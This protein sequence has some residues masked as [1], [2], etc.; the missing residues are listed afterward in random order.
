MPVTVVPTPDSSTSRARES[1]ARV[2]VVVD[3]DTIRLETGEAV[4]LLGVDTPEKG[5]PYFEEA[6]R[7]TKDLLVGQPVRLIL[8]AQRES[9]PYD[10]LL[11]FVEAGDRDPGLDLLQQ[12]LAR[13]LFI[14]PCGLDRAPLYRQAE[15]EAF[16][17]GRGIWS[18]QSRRRVNHE[19]AHRYVGSLMSVT[20]RVRKVH[21][22]PKAIHL[23]FGEDYRTD[24]TAVIYRK[25]L[26][27][28]LS[29][30]LEPVTTYAGRWVEVTGHLR[31]YQGPE[32]I[33]DAAD[34]LVVPAPQ[35]DAIPQT[36]NEPPLARP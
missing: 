16:R 14:P 22:G 32:I 27:G 15:R 29:K 33:V 23:D 24:F 2:E 10:R 11:A 7:L 9:D 36:H 31:S 35:E 13:T 6:S 19:E 20:G 12:G 21:T 17:A 28:L 25:N 8:C 18:L 4:R 26:T 34:Q 5:E 3:G 30:G 1:L